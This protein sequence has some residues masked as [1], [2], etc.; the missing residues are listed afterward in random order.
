MNTIMNNKDIIIKNSDKNLGI[1]IMSKNWYNTQVL[2]HLINY[3]CLTLLEYNI[4]I[5]LVKFKIKKLVNDYFLFLPKDYILSKYTLFQ[6][7]K[8]YIL[9]KVHKEPIASR[10]IAGAHSFITTPLSKVLNFLLLQHLNIFNTFDISTVC[11]N[12]LQV[13][14]FLD[15]FKSNAQVQILTFDI[16][17][18]YPN[19]TD[20]HFNYFYDQVKDLLPPYFTESLKI[21]F[22]NSIVT[23][24]D[25]CY[26]QTN[27]I[28]MGTPV[29]PTF[30]NI[31][32][33]L[34]EKSFLQNYE[35]ELFCF[36]RYID[37]IFIICSS[38]LS[39]TDVKLYLENTYQLKLKQTNSLP[40]SCSFLDLSIEIK[41]ISDYYYISYN[42]FQK[43]LN[44]YLYLPYSSNHSTST[45]KGWIVGELV[46]YSRNCSSVLGLKEVAEN[47]F[48]RLQARG[49]PVK[50]LNS[51]YSSFTIKC[52][53]PPNPDLFTDSFKVIYN[54]KNLSY[55]SSL[56]LNSNKIIRIY[57]NNNNNNVNSQN[58]SRK[59]YF[60]LFH[61]SRIS[62][63]H[64]NK[65]F[66]IVLQNYFKNNNNSIIRRFS[67][68]PIII[69]SK[70]LKNILQLMVN[71]S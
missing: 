70:N 63:S 38:S 62:Q 19:L 55:S 60:P 36:L 59:L 4:K 24:E 33:G 25:N 48:H 56:L 9:P 42:I 28:A 57:N 41:F 40:N 5:S 49:Y 71:Q 11:K 54:P 8:F 35:K 50:F 68:Y 51:I 13:I 1:A 12:S 21:I 66:L 22:E 69:T 27:G 30:C 46:R 31:L 6:D 29:A 43:P 2:S 16:E 15:K 37:D 7:P 34:L 10:P 45:I 14:S 3:K 61:L 26:L 65:Y 39:S 47:F 20:F 64:V 17:S 53:G 23:Y 52:L 58:D 67:D 44:N 32:L 18:L